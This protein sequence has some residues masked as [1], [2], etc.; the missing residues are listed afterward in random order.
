MW[1][2]YRIKVVEPLPRTT[3]KTR[4]RILERAGYNPFLIPAKYVTIDLISDSGTGAMTVEQWAK[5]LEA[6]EDFAGQTSFEQFVDAAKSLTGFPYIQPVH[7]G[8][9]AEKILF[10]LLLNR[11]DSVL[12][13]THFE[14]TRSNIESLKC[15]A[16]DLPSGEKPFRGNI[17]LAKLRKLMRSR[18]KVKLVILT[19]TSNILGGQPVSM[20]NIAAAQKIARHHGVAVVLDASRY[21]D[22]AFLIKQHGNAS[23]SIHAICQK[24]FG[25]ADI[26]YLS[27]KKDGLV[28]I[29]GFVGLRDGRLYNHLKYEIIRQEAFPTSGGLASRDLAAMTGGLADSTDEHFLRAHIENIRFLGRLLKE[30]HVD[31]Y[32]PVGGHAVVIMKKKARAHFAFALAA[33]IYIDSGIRVGIFDDCVRVAVPRRVYTREHLKYV[34]ECIAKAYSSSI[35]R[36]KLV[37]RPSEF[38]NF[39]ARYITA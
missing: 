28:N 18:K 16:I 8:R 7:Q 3:R 14:T 10:G 37:H 39:F 24:M 34:G 27:S 5:M 20:E 25:Y 23:G 4:K 15:H 35:P 17:D 31:I 38:F 30:N 32:E 11:G 9:S 12:A 22:N 6:R 26:A 1:E 2:P 13:N 29:G 36:L 33:Q 19:V 21:A